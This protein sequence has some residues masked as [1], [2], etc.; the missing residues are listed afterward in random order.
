V[1]E[2]WAIVVAAGRGD[3][4]GA[5]KQFCELAGVRVV[6]RSVAVAAQ[7]CDAVVVVLPEGVAW[8]GPPVAA[9]VTG[10]ATRSASVRA[11]LD[12]VSDAAEIVVVHDAARPLATA[13]LY[14]SVIRAIRDGADGAIP[15]VT[16]G[17]T[18]KQVDRARVI[19]TVD[20]EHLVAV[21]TP[22]GFR[23][24]RLREAH[25]GAGDASDDAALL[26]ATGARVVIVPGDLTNIKITAPFDLVV[27]RALVEQ[28]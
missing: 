11:G 4:F 8:D 10:G 7:A 20:R 21:Q 3:R 26:E 9:V 13:A 12:A 2:V 28:P 6:D 18:V 19:A 23:A 27:A 17:D 15:A 25:R 1:G 5:P 14:R 16:I 24:D 22:Q